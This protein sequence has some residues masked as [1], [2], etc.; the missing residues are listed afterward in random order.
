[1]AVNQRDDRRSQQRRV[2][3]R[4]GI[5]ALIEKVA[6][7]DTRLVTVME[8]QAELIKTN[9]DEHIAMNGRLHKTEESILELRIENR[10]SKRVILALLTVLAAKV[11]FEIFPSVFGTIK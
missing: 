2:D 1:M 7:L 9:K 3:D 8:Q 11:S 4:M 10:W 5:P 6:E